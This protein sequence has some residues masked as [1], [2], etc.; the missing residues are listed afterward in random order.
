MPLLSKLLKYTVT[1]QVASKIRSFK[2][3]MAS[4]RGHP[5]SDDKHSTTRY[6]CHY[7]F[8]KATK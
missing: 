2:A 3:K 4:F 7:R 6:L 8:Y 5:N 1:V